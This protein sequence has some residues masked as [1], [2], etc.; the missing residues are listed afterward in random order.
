[1]IPAAAEVSGAF[2][3]HG[4]GIFKEIIQK[5][6]DTLEPWE[7][8]EEP[9]ETFHLP[10]QVG[11]RVMA[12]AGRETPLWGVNP[13]HKAR[14][15]GLSPYAMLHRNDPRQRTDSATIELM[16]SVERPILTRAYPGEYMPPLPWMKSVSQAPDGKEGSIAFWQEHAF[17]LREGNAPA[18][19]T[20][21]APEW[22]APPQT[23]A[24]S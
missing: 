18:Q 1:M 2:L 3:P 6:L 21:Q 17:V 24:Q 20:G 22:Y 9:I 15:P 23:P 10:T 16:G 8:G 7:R 12:L 19:L 4:G 5:I 11:S 13:H 14:N